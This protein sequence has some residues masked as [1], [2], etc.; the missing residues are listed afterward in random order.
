MYERQN[1]FLILTTNKGYFVR[2][3]ISKLS[4]KKLNYSP[5]VE[6]YNQ[7]IK[8]L[9]FVDNV[10]KSKITLAPTHKQ[11]KS[12][13]VKKSSLRSMNISNI[14]FLKQNFIYRNYHSWKLSV[15]TSWAGKKNLTYSRI[16]IIK[17]GTLLDDHLKGRHTLGLPIL[18]RRQTPPPLLFSLYYSFCYLSLNIYSPMHNSHPFLV[19]LLQGWPES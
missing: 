11:T 18:F 12:Q 4:T 19:N 16:S 14:G 5:R 6:L 13:M 15:R 17:E 10:A 1:I 3:R 7:E 9:C 2:Q 8:C